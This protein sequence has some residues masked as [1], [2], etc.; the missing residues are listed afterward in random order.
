MANEFEKMLKE[1]GFGEYSLERAQVDA[2]RSTLTVRLVADKL[3]DTGA[4]Q[5]IRRLLS[6]R[7]AQC[8]V[9]V[10]IGCP[11]L[12]DNFLQNPSEYA[13][14]LAARLIQFAPGAA[15]FIRNAIW[16]NQNGRIVITMSGEVGAS[17][18]AERQCDV[19]LQ[20]VIK[21]TFQGDIAVEVTAKPYDQDGEE[22]I[23][24]RERQKQLTDEL[25]A[26]S[27]KLEEARKEKSL[28]QERI[29]LG[30]KI[31]GAVSPIGTL[32][33]DSGL[34]VVEGRVIQ[35]ESRLLRGETL[36]LITFGVTDNS[37]S[38]MVKVFADP[39]KGGALKQLDKGAGVRVK[40][41][42]RYDTYSEEIGIMARDVMLMPVDERMDKAEDK[43][44]ELHLHTQM[45]LMDGISP[46]KEL[47]QTAARWGHE[48]I[49]ITD[50]GVVQAFPEAFDTVKGLRKKGKDIKLIPGMEGYLV[51][52][53]SAIVD[54]ADS[55]SM[56]RTYVVLDVETTGFSRHSDR[57]TEVAAVRICDGKVVDEYTTFVN[58][59][60]PIPEVVVKLTNITDEM[61]R[62][63]PH[64]DQVIKELIEY[65]GQDVLCAHNAKFDMGFLQSTALRAGLRFPD[66][67]VVDT[68]PMARAL[69]PEMK[70]HKLNLVCK[71]L[72]V[73]LTGHHRA[74]N[75]TRATAQMF[76]RLMELAKERGCCTLAD[77]N[78]KFGLSVV[79][80]ND[81]RHVTL[82]VKNSQGLFHLYQLVSDSHLKY[83][84]RGP[85]IP[86]SV[87]NAHREGLLI[88]SACEEGE[89][90]QAVLCGKDED[91]LIRIASYY[92]FLEI[93]PTGNYGFMVRNED[94]ADEEALRAINRKIIELG[95]KTGKTVVATGDVHFIE[96]EQGIFRE[97]LMYNRHFRDKKEPAPLYFRTTTEMLEEFAYLGEETARQVVIEGP[98]A[99]AAMIEPIDMFP[100][101]PENKETFQPE[102]PNA[103][104]II[105]DTAV[106]KAKEIYGDDLP[107]V[108]QKRLDKELASIIGNG[109]ATLYRS[110]QL[111]VQKSNADGYL[112]GSRGSVGSS[113]VATMTGI[114]EVNPLPPHYV[115]PACKYS[116]FGVDTRE[117][118]C[119][120]DLPP[121]TCPHC[122]ASMN[123]DGYD[124]PFEVFLG[125]EGDKV[126]DIDLNF[127]GVYQP[128]A[129]AYTEE[130]FGKGNV[131]RAGTIGTLAEKNAYG[132]VMNYLEKTG[133]NA[134]MV[135]R[136]RLA[137]GITGVRKSTGQHPGG[138][139]IVPEEYK[140]YHFS[141]IQH[142]ADNAEG[143]TITTHFDFNSL[144]DI[145]VKL[146]I[147]GHD[148][149]TM[150]NMLE[151]L[152]GV[153]A[154][155][156]PLND[157][158][159]MSLFIGPDVLGVTAEQIGSKTGT[160]GIP[161]FGT[162]FVRGMLEETKPTTMAELIRISGLSHGTDVWL[163]NA[164]VMI[165]EGIATLRECFCTRDDIM[166][167]LM[168]YGMAPKLS[169]TI[170]E[171]VRKGRGLTPDMES[172]M[173]EAGVAP[174]YI[175]S[176]HKIQYMFPKAHAAAYVMMGLRVAYFKVYHPIQYYAAY[177]TV[178]AD[179]FDAALM[180]RA[181][182]ALRAA[183]K[184]IRDKD[185]DSAKDERLLTLIEI[186]LEMQERGLKFLPMDLY[187][188][189]ADEFL[190][191]D[192]AIR[193]PFN[194]LPGMGQ[195]AA[196]GI[197]AARKGGE[198][199][200]VED[201]RNRSKV[202]KSVIEQLRNEGC[203]ESLPESSQ[204]SLF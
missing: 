134:T 58:P 106:G 82:L 63:A 32:A 42:C 187:E 155:L 156:I 45:S 192:G 33:D 121:A 167:T 56:D 105:E 49:A 104:Q 67:P 80:G 161:E 131:Y 97:V 51:D 47:I 203:F 50:H 95:K 79:A 157:P 61:V 48:A 101:H 88:G 181:P 190:I 182:E 28:A 191:T 201:F 12:R 16:S 204:I 110:A 44:I 186:S 15:P 169:F 94:V 74:I 39:E 112:V 194:R 195:A 3:P 164:Q 160:L 75:D 168:A 53:A 57:L 78:E 76:M 149:P 7:F 178:R 11:A 146:D 14:Y 41:E 38:I 175:D 172:A 19:F 54:R 165:A 81:S 180:C 152:T 177:F 185:D 55:G 87:L 143:G 151:R 40:G 43:R 93:Q 73:Q 83:H 85:K 173:R 20:R 127:S 103:P 4:E 25:M 119:G 84:F 123:R 13:Q 115:C 125:F 128:V 133:K 138:M 142:P 183:M 34:V 140:V 111:L 26:E 35:A 148:D 171:A 22:E 200:S 145:L 71:Q 30:S 60:K 92:D 27:R 6:K 5:S 52:D 29:L 117:Y 64:P 108:V 18:M 170:M 158:K 59:G 89:L 147:L 31:S 8:K 23:M 197:V 166:N 137:Q 98:R 153:D 196:E 176:C 116:D 77:L 24:R 199:L 136:E 90:F 124:I 122:G 46:A 91:E 132:E 102:L 144:H 1:E 37:G 99:V 154:K 10:S 162:R 198:F 36:M 130:L 129:H 135:E 202:S 193:P 141:P 72:G 86:R 189:S 150:I 69:L 179:E 174:H 163:N 109:F 184:E 188:S 139:V 65:V 21:E 159:V 68:L 2:Q 96:P 66:L 62:N 107:E 17:F 118:P 70:G 113:F 100:K 114:T 120:V 9:K 126:P